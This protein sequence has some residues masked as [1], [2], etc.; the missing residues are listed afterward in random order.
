MGAVTILYTL[1]DGEAVNKC[2]NETRQNGGRYL[3]HG[4]RGQRGEQLTERITNRAE[5]KRSIVK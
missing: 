1:C 4:F 5:A 3:P 2:E